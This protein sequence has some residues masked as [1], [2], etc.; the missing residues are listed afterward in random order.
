MHADELDIDLSLVRRLVAAQLPQWSALPVD[1]VSS[2]GTVNAIFRLGDDLT[3]RLPRVATWAGDLEKELHWLPKLAPHL[4]LAVPEPVAGGE[5]GDGY[6]WR[7]AVYRWLEG[8]TWAVDRVADLR[9]AATEL[10]R[11]VTALQ[12]VDATEALVS[13]PGGR[14]RP[15][16]ERD[17]AVRAA[18]AASHGLVD[19]DAVTAAWESALEAPV[20]DGPPVLLHG[21]LLP[22]NVLVARGRVSAVIDWGALSV[23]DPACE[24]MAGWALFAGRSRAL[25]REALSVDDAT[26]ARA[27]G[28]MLSVALIALPYYVDTNPAFAANAR[29]WIG[30]VLAEHASG[31]T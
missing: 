9:G 6:P 27:R 29:H 2:T 15:L 19:T 13:G 25:F 3:V 30:E 1:P 14:G 12:Q 18:I 24:L 20:W 8:E 17:A 7:W 31:Q 26:W 23:G 11:F 5:P 16:A 22:G 4:P 10:A 28:W 21:D